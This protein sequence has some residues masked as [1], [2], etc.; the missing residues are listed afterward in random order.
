FKLQIHFIF[1]NFNSLLVD[2]VR[3]KF[4]AAYFPMCRNLAQPLNAGVTVFRVHLVAGDDHRLKDLLG[5]ARAYLG[6][7]VTSRSMSRMSRSSR[8]MSASISV[9]GRG[10]WYW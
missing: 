7:S 5:F 8:L 6:H 4:Q 1:A 2:V 3:Q 9:S 10:G